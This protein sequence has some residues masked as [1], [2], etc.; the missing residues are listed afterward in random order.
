MPLSHIF[1][2]RP[3]KSKIN[4]QSSCKSD[5]SLAQGQNLKVPRT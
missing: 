2:C 5:E 3:V 1:A 4:N